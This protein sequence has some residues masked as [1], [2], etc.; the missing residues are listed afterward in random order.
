[1]MTSDLGKI[2]LHD[3][4]VHLLDPGLYPVVAGW[5]AGQESL[6]KD[7]ESAYRAT[8]SGTEALQDRVRE[9]SFLKPCRTVL[10]AYMARA[11]ASD[12]KNGREER[13]KALGELRLYVRFFREVKAQIGCAGKP[14][15][16]RVR[17]DLKGVFDEYVAMIRP[18]AVFGRFPCAFDEDGVRI[19]GL[20]HPFASKSL[21][22]FYT[23]KWKKEEEEEYASYSGE[24]SEFK[25]P[26]ECFLFA[27]TIGPGVDR[28]VARLS[29][30]GENYRALLLNAIGAGAA[31]MVAL[32]LELYLNDGFPSKERRWRRFHV[33]YGDFKLEEQRQL[34]ARLD[35]SRIGIEL[36]PS[37]LMIPEKSVSGIVALKHVRIRE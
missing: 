10:D 25:P 24:R 28:E 15:N 2:Q 5:Y 3:P 35:P 1:M 30:E 20:D 12:R 37:C 21:F 13:L 16:D 27:A 32:D 18:A 6:F 9:D 26:E 36:N 19:E 29:D 11:K 4:F 23:T 34:F 8:T 31:D 22:R 14:V 7:L 17:E 33:G